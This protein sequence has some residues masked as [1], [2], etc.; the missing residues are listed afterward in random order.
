MV[1]G[2]YYCYSIDIQAF[3]QM[4]HVKR[5]KKQVSKHSNRAYKNNQNIR[6][7]GRLHQPGGASCQ[8]RR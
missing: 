5:E 2:L 1:Y 7:K 4:P 8:Q 6:R 3:Q